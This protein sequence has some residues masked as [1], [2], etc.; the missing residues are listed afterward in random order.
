MLPL[1]I[2]K[3]RK[4][5]WK[6][7]SRSTDAVVSSISI[8]EIP[9]AKVPPKKTTTTVINPIIDAIEYGR[10]PVVG[11]VNSSQCVSSPNDSK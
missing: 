3:R 11:D 1:G 7:S 6:F 5:G 9:A 8:A 10:Q 4:F 2:K